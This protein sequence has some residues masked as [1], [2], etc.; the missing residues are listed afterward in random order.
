MFGPKSPPPSPLLMSLSVTPYSSRV[1][2]FPCLLSCVLYFCQF[3]KYP[4]SPLHTYAPRC[5][6]TCWSLGIIS[7]PVSLK[8]FDFFSPKSHQLLTA[9]QPTFIHTGNFSGSILCMPCA[10]GHSSFEFM[11]SY[12][13]KSGWSCFVR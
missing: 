2:L 6:T 12:G 10:C 8:N 13:V 9:H 4:L 5:G 11:G 1:C 3:L 7:G